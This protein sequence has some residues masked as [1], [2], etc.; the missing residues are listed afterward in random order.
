[1]TITERFQTQ[2]YTNYNKQLNRSDFLS[3]RNEEGCLILKP[4]GH[5]IEQTNNIN[6]QIWRKTSTKANKENL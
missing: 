5:C 1:M 4:I 6:V 3:L 2:Y